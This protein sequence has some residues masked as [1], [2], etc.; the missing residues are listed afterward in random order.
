[1][2]RG[3]TTNRIGRGRAKSPT[4]EYK[5]HDLTEVFFLSSTIDRDKLLIL[6]P[7][8]SLMSNRNIFL[9]FLTLLFCLLGAFTISI[10]AAADKPNIL[11][12]WGP[13]TSPTSS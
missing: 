12:I 8:V 2:L 1:M 9:R 7:E 3:D 5:W 10:A 6:S 11:V 13:P 4:P